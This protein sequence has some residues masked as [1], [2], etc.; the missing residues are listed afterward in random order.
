MNSIRHIVKFIYR[1]LYLKYRPYYSHFDVFENINDHITYE[2]LLQGLN[3]NINDI[4]TERDIRFNHLPFGSSTKDL[5]KKIGKP[6]FKFKHP[7]IENIVSYFYRRKF[8]P[9]KATTLFCFYN[10]NLIFGSF[11]F[12]NINTS[13]INELE[14]IIIEKY[15]GNTDNTANISKI[16]DSH[17]NKIEIVRSVDFRINFYCGNKSILLK[18]QEQRQISDTLIT[19]KVKIAYSN[20]YNLL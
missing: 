14:T 4:N 15:L 20:L 5:T 17:L 2:R 18:L 13:K 3:T 19:Q 6:R 16:L 11:I 1:K 10:D 8:G 7:H 12:D 9:L